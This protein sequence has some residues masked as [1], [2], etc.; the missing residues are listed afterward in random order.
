MDT[1]NSDDFMLQSETAKVL[2][3]QY[4]KKYPIVDYH[5]HVIPQEIFEDRRYDNLTQLWLGGD[6]YKWRLM[7][8]AG[9]S[10][11]LITGKATDIDKFKAFA[12]V[13]GLSIGNPIYHWCFLELKRY[14]DIDIPLSGKT[15]KEIWD[16]TEKKL[17]S[18]EVTA[19]SII[20]D[21]NVE[22][23]CTTDDPADDLKWHIK[24]NE[25]KTFDT[26]VLPTFRPDNA[27]DI[28][29]KSFK[30]YIDT[31]SKVSNTEIR[32]LDSLKKALSA[33]MDFFAHT[34]CCLADHGTEFIYFEKGSREEI[35][36]IIAKALEGKELT[37]QEI[38][39]Y[40]T[41][42]FIFCAEEYKKRSWTMQLHFGCI[43]DTNSR[44]FEYY[45]PNVGC[46]A[47][48]GGKDYIRPLSRYF[49]YLTYNN[50]M[51]DII[52]YSLDPEDNTAL[53]T[54]IGCFRKVRHGA[55]WWFNDQHRGM[56]DMLTR[57]ASQ[58]YFPSFP[59]MLTDSRCFLSYTRHEYFRR[60]LCNLM[61]DYVE[62]NMFPKDFDIL[63]Q[64]LERVC[65][66]NS[67]DIFKA[68]K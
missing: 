45:G 25:D 52:V 2:Y 67:A 28:Q 10:E 5:S 65:Y 68:N 58:T 29:K 17:N 54:L 4:A 48:S 3:N 22:L 64:I 23:L 61:G 63:S 46:D 32:D 49:D 47:I 34:G 66:K 43:R 57:L 31:L 13:V 9:I 56:E 1:I 44:M 7:R 14:F 50:I 37:D 51:P 8:A 36:Q 12:E 26:K 19:R 18:G 33:R 60:I 41:E 24:I 53:D 15:W 42:L 55:A 27:V 39:K 40:K 20:R 62:K 16:I 59:G 38:A 30:D 6:H 35:D 11:D 21:S